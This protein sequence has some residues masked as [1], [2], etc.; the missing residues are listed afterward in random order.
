LGD[1]RVGLQVP[2][3]VNVHT[4]LVAVVEYTPPQVVGLSTTPK[5]V[6]MITM[7]EPPLYPDVMP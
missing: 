2:L 1:W 3:A 5:S 6:E 4:S 7:P